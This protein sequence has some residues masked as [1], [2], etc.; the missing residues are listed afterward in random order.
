VA[1]Y[2]RR[3]GIDDL[4]GR[5]A[6]ALV[7]G[8]FQRAGYAVSRTGRESQ[9]QRS[10]KKGR[11]EFLPDFLVRKAVAR[12][13][14]ERPLHRLVSIEVKFR[15]HL[16]AYIEGEGRKDVAQAASW[17]DLYLVLVTDRPAPGRSCFQ[18][19]DPRRGEDATADL[20]TVV[21]L[22]IYER[23][24]R[25]YEGLV[26]RIFRLLDEAT[27]DGSRDVMTALN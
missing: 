26:H 12:E 10:L 6:E 14:S 4:K 16:S 23:T 19:L 11:T 20:H 24:V 3:H 7:E 22:D 15:R 18:V 5:I 25:E 13:D 1:G 2:R 9:V 27:H 8:I 21:D 17:P